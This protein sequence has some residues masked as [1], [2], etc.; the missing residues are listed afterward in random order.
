MQEI[1]KA[2]KELHEERNKIHEDQ[3]ALLNKAGEEKRD[4]N[5]DEETNYQ[6][7]DK[8]FDELTTAIN[9]KRTELDKL[10]ESAARKEKLENRDELLKQVETGAIRPEPEDRKEDKKEEKRIVSIYDTPEYRNAF[11]QFLATSI[12]ADEFRARLGTPELRTNTL[13]M[14][15]DTYGGFL[16]APVAFV[17]DLIADLKR[18][19]FMRNICKTYDMPQAAEI[20]RPVLDTDLADSDWTAEIRTGTQGD[21]KFEGRAFHPHPSAKRIKVSE[22]LVRYAGVM[23][24]IEALVRDRMSYKFAV[25]EEKAFMTGDGA[26]KPLGIFTASDYGIPSGRNVNTANTSSA[27]KADNL[28]EVVGNVEKQWRAGC[29]WIMHRTLVTAIRRLKDGS[30]QYLWVAGFGV[31]PDTILGYP[32]EESEYAQDYT[33]PAAS[34]RYAVF[35]NFQYYE[36]YTALDMR[37]R[38]LDQLYAET[39]EIGYIGR[40]EVDGAPIRQNAFSCSATTA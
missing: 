31:K 13:Q 24:G 29:R 19:T 35:G 6:N 17:G 34:T 2:L 20:Q 27:I 15:H 21:L 32:V 40:M 39:N 28:I 1:E 5:A 36:I 4:L 23:G 12:S 26:G 33:T 18:L 37:V 9:E 11:D 8:R 25:T 22:T 3:K 14:D 38:V 10:K 30:G 7:M 16:V